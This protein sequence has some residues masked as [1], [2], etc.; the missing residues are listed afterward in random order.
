MKLVLI[1][2][3][4]P[5]LLFGQAGLRAGVARVDITPPKGH[6]MAG[7]SERTHGA[8]GVRD[9]LYATVLLLES[10]STT[11]ALIACDLAS[12]TSTRIAAEARRKFGIANTV[13]SMS[14]TH[15]G[16][17]P[18]AKWTASAE[19]KIAAAIGEARQSMFPATISS[20]SGR[21]YLAFNRRK[22]QND[23]TARLWE[24][25]PEGLPS[26]PLDPA[27]NVLAVRDAE[28]IRAVLVHF[29][30]RATV[31]GPANLEFSADY[32]G[33]LRRQVE[34]QTPGALCLFLQG[35]S[36]DIS[37][38]RN[39]E[40]GRVPAFEAAEKMGRDLSAEVLRA[41]PRA[42]PVGDGAT[43]QIASEQI[44]TAGRTIAITAGVLGGLCFLAV[45]G[46]P[47]IEHQMAFQARSEC[48]VP[49]LVGSSYSGA[50]VWAGYL[51]SIRAAAEGGPGTGRDSL[52]PPGTA[53]MLVD[54]GAIALFKVRGLLQELP[55]PR[56]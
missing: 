40:P 19:E 27:V 20:A 54:R 13:L 33:A 34:S 10:G 39:N 50:G 31:L 23:G 22:T 32:P 7:Y 51:P 45:P 35:A 37:P 48:A 30:A 44:Q 53:E 24:R 36:G 4:A 1:A 5:A 25:N 11:A 46:E 55:D 52:L 17:A 15:S 12:F 21:A 8:T 41:L 56:F 16:P 2:V 6:P 42:R 18:S 28:K 43:L 14:G 26:H 49:L 9:P 47:F 3:L 29:A 38:D